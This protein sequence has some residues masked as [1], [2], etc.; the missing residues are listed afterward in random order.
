MFRF[1][2]GDIVVYENTHEA[3]VISTKIDTYS[4]NWY[5]IEFSADD[6]IPPQMTVKEDQLELK[7]YTS[8]T[9]CPICLDKWKVTR[10]GMAVW[11]DC[12]NCGDSK[13]NL[14]AKAKELHGAR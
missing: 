6:L 3:T 7:P 1:N 2:I 4:R 9:N 5:L 11:Y 12:L 8:K 14:V 13:E 10:F